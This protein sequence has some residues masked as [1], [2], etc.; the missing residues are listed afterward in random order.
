MTLLRAWQLELAHEDAIR[1]LKQENDKNVHRAH[2]D[3]SA[4]RRTLLSV[5]ALCCCSLPLLS[6][7]ALYR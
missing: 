3:L 5:A 7:A 1:E 2:H 6:A 4:A